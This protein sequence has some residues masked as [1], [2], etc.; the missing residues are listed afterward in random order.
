MAK[1]GR[2]VPV[3]SRIDGDV[4]G[5]VKEAAARFAALHG[6]S[7]REEQVLAFAA[8]GRANKEIA[9]LL[10]ISYRTVAEYW[11]RTCSKTG[12]PSSA[13][14]LARLLRHALGAA[15]PSVG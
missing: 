14:V 15:Q 6:L 4:P 7:R 8:D 10:G 12:C 13:Q 2:H 1:L 11:L 3:V 9:G 5:E